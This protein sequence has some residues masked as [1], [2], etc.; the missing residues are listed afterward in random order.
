[1]MPEM[2]GFEFINELRKVEAWRDIPIVVVTALD[3]TN[4][5]RARLT[6]QVH[7]VLQKGAYDRESLLSEVRSLVTSLANTKTTS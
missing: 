1:M 7:Q 4:E 3:L 6:S 2:D 5:D